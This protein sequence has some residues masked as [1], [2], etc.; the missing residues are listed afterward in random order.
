MKKIW[1]D[2]KSKLSKK[3]ERAEANARHVLHKEYRQSIKRAVENAWQAI[4]NDDLR[5]AS[6]YLYE[7][8]HYF[9]KARY[10]NL[11]IFY[12][13]PLA[14]MW[15]VLYLAFFIGIVFFASQFYPN[16]ENNITFPI[17]I[18]L[19]G[20]G[21]G[22]ATAVLSKIVGLHLKTQA[23]TTR[24]TWYF[25]KPILGAIMGTLTY[26]AILSG[27]TIFTDTP[28]VNNV[29][30]VFLTGFLGGYLESFSTRI[31]NEIADKMVETVNQQAPHDE[32]NEQDNKTE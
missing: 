20:G 17:L 6:S 31:L 32:Q 16:Q 4:E 7:A 27:L 8:E 21:I 28:K 2:K 9:D 15:S 23:I 30:G 26:F 5:T 12:N 14:I 18:A 25:I 24:V 19:A 29:P 1:P 10:E 13:T 11:V 22:G 3:V